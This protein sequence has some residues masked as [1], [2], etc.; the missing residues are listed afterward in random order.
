VVDGA[1]NGTA[2]GLGGLSARMRRWQN[3]FVR[4]YAMSMLVG[5]VVVGAMLAM[6]RL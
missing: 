5:A 3:G 4:S 2:A 1:V 6:V